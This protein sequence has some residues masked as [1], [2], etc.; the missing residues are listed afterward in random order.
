MIGT[1]VKKEFKMFFFSTFPDSQ[2]M[3]WSA[4]VK[5]KRDNAP[6]YVS[7]EQLPFPTKLGYKDYKLI[8]VRSNNLISLLLIHKRFR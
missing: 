6:Q 7:Y 2:R 1:S 5:D 8:S 3:Q 4:S